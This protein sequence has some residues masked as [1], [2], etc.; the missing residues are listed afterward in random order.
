MG[1]R[2]PA[3]PASRPGAQSRAPGGHSPTWASPS[4]GPC[5]GPG[6]APSRCVLCPVFF[7]GMP[8]GFSFGHLFI[9]LRWGSSIPTT[10]GINTGFHFRHFIREAPWEGAGG[11]PPPGAGLSAAPLRTGTWS[12]ARAC[13]VVCSCLPRRFPAGTATELQVAKCCGWLSAGPSPGTQTRSGARTVPRA[14]PCG[15]LW[16]GPCCRPST[17]APAGPPPG[18][19]SSSGARRASSWP[20]AA[21]CRGSSC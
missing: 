1:A 4:T 13:T 5:G 17:P 14:V 12:R 11:C 18:L 3:V 8:R 21:A 19:R 6:C 16:A 2:S 7:I 10:Q 15:R 9:N 20:A